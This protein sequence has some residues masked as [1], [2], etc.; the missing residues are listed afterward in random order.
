[1][2]TSNARAWWV[3]V[4]GALAVTLSALSSIAYAAPGDTIADRVLGQL[5]FDR[6]GANMTANNGLN[7]PTG[8]AIDKSATPNRIY[9]TDSGNNRV[10]GWHDV[11][12]FSN[13]AP[14]DI[15]IG[16]PNFVSHG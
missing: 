1:M 15:V 13:G 3:V 14:A 11:S 6:D 4:C 12:A 16:Q 5:A 9:V 10:L 2:F 8:V 7:F